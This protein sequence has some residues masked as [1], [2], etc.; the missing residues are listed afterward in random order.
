M[1]CSSSHCVKSTKHFSRKPGPCAVRCP[2]LDSG[3]K[4]RLSTRVQ[5]VQRAQQISRPQPAKCSQSSLLKACLRAPA[6]GQ[7]LGTPSGTPT[8]RPRQ[9]LQPRPSQLAPA[10]YAVRQLEVSVQAAASLPASSDPAVVVA[11]AAC[12][13][14][15]AV[16]RRGQGPRTHRKLMRSSLHLVLVMAASGVDRAGV[17]LPAQAGKGH[18]PLAGRPRHRRRVARLDVPQVDHR[19]VVPVRM[20]LPACTRL[21][22]HCSKHPSPRKSGQWL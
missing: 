10:A 12:A 7:P 20:C 9:P 14:R 1:G 17:Q 22:S 13:R 15:R 3:V 16:P 19:C 6:R 5:R 18:C 4:T 2:L 8:C 11:L 21:H